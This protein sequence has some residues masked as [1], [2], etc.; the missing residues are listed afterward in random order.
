MAQNAPTN[1]PVPFADL[2]DVLTPQ[3]AQAL[4]HISRATFFRWVQAGKLP[5]AVKIGDSWRVVRDQLWAY[6][7][8]EGRRGGTQTP[9]GARPNG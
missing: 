4:L 1:D 3:Q 8:R 7:Q 2:P 9:V 6:L 5:G